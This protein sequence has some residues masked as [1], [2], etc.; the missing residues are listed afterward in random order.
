MLIQD[1]YSSRGTSESYGLRLSSREGYST[2]PRWASRAYS[3][4]SCDEY[5]GSENQN[6]TGE[7][8]AQTPA[9]PAYRRMPSPIS[10]A[11]CWPDLHVVLP[12]PDRYAAGA[13]TGPG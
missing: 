1:R 6:C 10:L 13:T 12:A 8:D 9:L 4:S 2:R 11:G 3:H 5:A 7:R